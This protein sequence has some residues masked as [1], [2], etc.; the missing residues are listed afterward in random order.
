MATKKRTKKKL[1]P[2]IIGGAAIGIVGI[3]YLIYSKWFKKSEEQINCESQGGRW[4]STNNYCELPVYKK[5]IEPIEPIKQN[6]AI[7]G[8]IENIEIPKQQKKESGIDLDK[9]IK[10]GDKGNLVYRVQVAINNI[11]K[12]R[13]VNSYKDKEKGKTIAFPLPIDPVNSSFGDITDSAAKYAFGGEYTGKG[14]TTLRKARE[15]WVRSAGY[16]GKPF[17]TELAN[18]SNYD[19][20]QKIYVMNV[21]KGA[22]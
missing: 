21:A 4:D 13:G 6:N 5:P 8:A 15:Q 2:Y 11:A 3:G 1:N 10:K 18:V 17:P 16:A 19:D 9:K 7:G 12:L 22:V 20:L 14:Y